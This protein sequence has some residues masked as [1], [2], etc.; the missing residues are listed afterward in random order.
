MLTTALFYV[1]A[2]YYSANSKISQNELN[3][4]D[5]IRQNLL[6]NESVLSLTTESADNLKNFAGINAVQDAQRWSE[7]LLSTSNPYIITNILSSSNIKYIYAAQADAELL[8]SSMLNSF[9]KYFSQVF[10]NDYATIYA[11]PPITAPSSEASLGVLDFS[12]SLE[13]PENTPTVNAANTNLVT[14]RFQLQPQLGA[15]IVSCKVGDSMD[16]MATYPPGAHIPTATYS[17]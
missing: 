3:S 17:T 1:N 12:P 9:V 14:S 5:Y 13:Q 8:T 15:T 4:F 11:V 7:L 10:K 6:F 2:S 16:R